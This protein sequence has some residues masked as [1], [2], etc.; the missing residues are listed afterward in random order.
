M[1][2]SKI[3]S[4]SCLGT[5]ATSPDWNSLYNN[6]RE[7]GPTGVD[8]D[9]FK[10]DRTAVTWQLAQCV[11]N[12]INAWYDDSPEIQRARIIAFEDMIF[13]YALIGKHLTRKRRGNPSGNPL[14]TELNNCVNYLMLCMVYL[15]IAKKRKPEQYG[16]MQWKKN[17]NMKAYGDD[18]IFTVNPSCKEWFDLNDLTALYKNFGVPVT[19]AD[20]SDAGIVFKSLHELTFLKRTFRPFDHHWCKWQGALDKTSI[21][22]MIQFYRL[23][24]NNGTIEDAMYTNCHESLK[25]AYHWGKDFFEEHLSKIN[26]WLKEHHYSVIS[27]TYAELDFIFRDKIA[28]H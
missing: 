17:I 7:T 20:K 6:L 3:V 21:R 8:L 15:L 24:P 5:D 13:S 18:I 19:P 4:F 27:I 28:N 25:E 1:K 10:F 22:N 16:I 23:K 14:T 12:A 26:S 9:F 11:C 2:N